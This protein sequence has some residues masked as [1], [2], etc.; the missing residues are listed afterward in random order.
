MIRDAKDDNKLKTY[1][2]NTLIISQYRELS[3]QDSSK[4]DGMTEIKNKIVRA[5]W[6][7]RSSAKGTYPVEVEGQWE[8]HRG[9]VIRHEG[10]NEPPADDVLR[11]S[12][13]RPLDLSTT[14]RTGGAAENGIFSEECEQWKSS[15]VATCTPPVPQLDEHEPQ[16]EACH[17]A[18]QCSERRTD[19][20]SYSV[21]QRTEKKLTIFAFLA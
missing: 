19:F 4:R 5:G 20:R 11:S 21:R 1:E 8:G 3:S 6:V 13:P 15:P 17:S 14:R 7:D 2:W 10:T 9:A 12:D 16:S 18:L